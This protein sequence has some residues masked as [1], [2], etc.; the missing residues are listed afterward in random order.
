VTLTLPIREVVPATPRARIARLDLQ[1]QAFPFQPGQAALLSSPGSEKKRAYSIAS[2]PEDAEAENCLEFLVGVDAEGQP[3]AHLR[4]EPQAL[5]EVEGPLGRFTFPPEPVE[6]RFVFIA[7]GTGIAPLRSMMRHALRGP[8]RQIGVL[9]S[10]RTPGE[11][12]YEDELRAL[13]RDG[14]IEL[15]QTITRD[16]PA[17]HWIGR[18]GRIGRD[19]LAPLVHNPE[20]LCFICGPPALVDEIPKLLEELGVARQR[21]RIEEWESK[22]P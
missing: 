12:A 17:E 8:H 2:P 10:A 4:L 6:Q 11:F 18:R 5:V 14:R 9:Y 13:A 3:G 21:I 15:K 7:G 1:D 22:K 19:D 20:T 16:A